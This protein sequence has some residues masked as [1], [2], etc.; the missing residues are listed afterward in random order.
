MTYKINL[1]PYLGHVLRIFDDGDI[2]E[3]TMNQIADDV[4]LQHGEWVV[5]Y[6]Q[7]GQHQGP[8]YLNNGTQ[9]HGAV[10][11][12][13]WMQRSTRMRRLTLTVQRVLLG[14]GPGL[15]RRP[16]GR[17]RGPPKP[18]RAPRPRSRL[19]TRVRG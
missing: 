16:R 17:P 6:T 8:I 15:D 1:P 10:T 13:K 11:H 7:L 12:H 18:P 3:Q 19:T 5:S 9:W 14:T 2:F 4:G